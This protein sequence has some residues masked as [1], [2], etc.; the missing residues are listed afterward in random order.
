MNIRHLISCPHRRHH[1][2]LHTFLPTTV[3]IYLLHESS[4][5]SLSIFLSLPTI[6]HPTSSLTPPYH[7]SQV[8]PPS[9]APAPAPQ[10]ICSVEQ[11]Q[12]T[13][14]T[15]DDERET[16]NLQCTR[17]PPFLRTGTTNVSYFHATKSHVNLSESRRHV[18]YTVM[19][20]LLLQTQSEYEVKVI[21][22]TRSHLALRTLYE[23]QHERNRFVGMKSI[24]KS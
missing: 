23:R 19:P 7:Y 10:C 11:C 22:A 16:P 15:I 14:T 5:S 2:S 17:T 6:P 3:T 20:H 21:R 12:L 24:V 9:P 18:L 8:L 4:P 1:Y 13:A